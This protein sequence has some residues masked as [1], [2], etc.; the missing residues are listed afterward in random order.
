MA[1][2]IDGDHIDITGLDK[3]E[4]LVA[5]FNVAKPSEVELAFPLDNKLS[6]KEAKKI[7]H[8]NLKQWGGDRIDYIKGREIKVNLFRNEINVAIYNGRNGK[9]LAQTALQPLLRKKQNATKH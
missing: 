9:N 3:A 4:V 7:I 5:L 1:D 8:Q 2:F 6:L